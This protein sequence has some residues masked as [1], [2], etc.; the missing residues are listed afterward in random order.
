MNNNIDAFV[1]PAINRLPDYLQPNSNVSN[2]RKEILNKTLECLENR[3]WFG[4][5]KIP[6]LMTP[7][8]ESNVPFSISTR[9]KLSE[10]EVFKNLNRKKDGD[11][12]IT[13]KKKLKDS[14]EDF[15][16]CDTIKV[17]LKPHD[18]G[19]FT[20]LIAEGQHRIDVLKM[21]DIAEEDYYVNVDVLWWHDSENWRDCLDTITTINRI[22]MKWALEDYV[23]SYAE[24]DSRDLK[25]GLVN[26][27]PYIDLQQQIKSYSKILTAP[28]VVGAFTGELTQ[29][30]AV[31]EGTYE[32]DYN[33]YGYYFKVLGFFEDIFK[34]HPKDQIG[35][36]ALRRFN[37]YIHEWLIKGDCQMELHKFDNA[38]QSLRIVVKEWC[39]IHH[40]A[41]QDNVNFNLMWKAFLNGNKDKTKGRTRTP[42]VIK[43]QSY[44]DWDGIPRTGQDKMALPKNSLILVKSKAA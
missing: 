12:S 31:R 34:S 21:L 6:F 22:M 39:D 29:H 2:D 15:G 14:I 4:D 32:P 28:I 36:A 20:F 44:Q 1:Y 13:H 41:P 40:I 7:P 42:I 43:G 3:T 9:A 25:G 10:F 23:N 18:D 26:K 33:K 30:K 8:N 37:L 16:F 5:N 17:F 19:T 35:I 11:S 24:G 27:T 38:L